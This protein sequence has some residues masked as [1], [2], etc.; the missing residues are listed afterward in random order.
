VPKGLAFIWKTVL[1]RWITSRG[2]TASSLVSTPAPVARAV[3]PLLTHPIGADK[4]TEEELEEARN[5]FC[6]GRAERIAKLEKQM[7]FI[8]SRQDMQ[9]ESFVWKCYKAGLECS[10]HDS[11]ERERGR[12]MRVNGKAVL[13]QDSS[14]FPKRGEPGEGA[15]L[16]MAARA[17]AQDEA[18]DPEELNAPPTALQGDP[19]TARSYV[20]VR[21]TPI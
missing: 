21:V 3:E 5:S 13:V 15:T 9:S 4:V 7:E 20:L 1:K 12:S 8:E 17:F 18:C 10:V 6:F 14:H 11:D 19:A 16:W 2:T